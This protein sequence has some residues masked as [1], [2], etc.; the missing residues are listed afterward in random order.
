MESS[1]SAERRA[2]FTKWHH[3]EQSGALSASDWS[4]ES[5]QDLDQK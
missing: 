4:S 1:R 2:I 3:C 5:R